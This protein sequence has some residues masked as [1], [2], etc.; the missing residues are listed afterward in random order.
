MALRDDRAAIPPDRPRTA[1]WAQVEDP[2]VDPSTRDALTTQVD[3]SDLFE[4]T[5][6]AVVEEYMPEG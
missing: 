1:V 2:T 6:R 3:L 5:V 4:R